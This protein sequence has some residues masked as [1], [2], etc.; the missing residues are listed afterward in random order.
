MDKRWGV[1]L[2]VMGGISTIRYLET[3]V[4]PDLKGQ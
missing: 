3:G 1:V 2:I 4:A